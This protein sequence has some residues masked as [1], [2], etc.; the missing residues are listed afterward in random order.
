MKALKIAYF[1][2][3]AAWLAL[4][5]MLEMLPSGMVR[6]VAAVGGALCILNA[7]VGVAAFTMPT[8]GGAA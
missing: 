7:F 1:T 2:G 4:V 5:A 8:K 6:P 3:L